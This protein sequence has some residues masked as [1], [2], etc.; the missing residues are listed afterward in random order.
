MKDIGRG[1]LISIGER[2]KEREHTGVIDIN[3]IH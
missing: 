1:W 2:E 3:L